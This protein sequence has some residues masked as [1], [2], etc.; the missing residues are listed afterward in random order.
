[1][2]DYVTLDWSRDGVIWNN[3]EAFAGMSEG[4]PEYSL[5][6]AKFW[7]PKGPVYVRFRLTSDANLSFPPYPGVAIDDVTL[8][9]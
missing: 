6:A 2:Y 5:H 8:K 3:I 4:F 9:A 7:A 1:D